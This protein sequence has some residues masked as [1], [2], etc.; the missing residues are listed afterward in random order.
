MIVLV[1]P[2]S[3]PHCSVLF[4]YSIGEPRLDP[5]M[6]VLKS[7]LVSKSEKGKITKDGVALYIPDITL[8]KSNPP[9]YSFPK[10]EKGGDLFTSS[11]STA[12]NPGAIYDLPGSIGDY[13]RNKGITFAKGSKEFVGENNEHSLTENATVLSLEQASNVPDDVL[14]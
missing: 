8:T 1:L 9:Q 12:S 4:F 2:L 11:S 5:S 14:G 6:V 10:T 3:F 13:D 7:G